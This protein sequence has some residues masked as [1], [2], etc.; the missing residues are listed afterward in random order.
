M[1]MN[2]QFSKLNSFYFLKGSFKPIV[3]GF[4]LLLSIDFIVN[5]WCHKK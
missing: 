2:F 4:F 1:I 5:D 3:L